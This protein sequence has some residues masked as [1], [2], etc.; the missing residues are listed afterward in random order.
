MEL[1]PAIKPVLVVSLNT[2][3]QKTLHFGHLEYGDV[4][5]A[6]LAKEC[7]G[8]KGVNVVRV[9]RM[10]GHHCMFAGF[11]GGETGALL[12]NEIVS[13]GAIDLSV[14]VQTKTRRCTTVISDDDGKVTELI[15]PSGDVSFS[16]AEELL[17]RIE[18]AVPNCSAVLFVGSVPPGTPDDFCEKVA[19]AANNCNVPF[20][21][22]AVA[23]LDAL[24]HGCFLLKVNAAELRKIAGVENLEEGAS[25]V[26]RKFPKLNAIGVTDGANPAHLFKGGHHWI[27]KVPRLDKIVS[28]IGG[29]DCTDAILTLRIAQGAENLPRAFAEALASATAS[30]LTDTP[31]AFDPELAEKLTSAIS[32]EPI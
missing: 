20:V 14:K 32:I 5:R 3:W 4:N 2:A 30:C 8:G 21:L 27:F 23:G 25:S 15:E 28:P 9:L 18:K 7:G 19:E 6:R 31:S 11:H 17:N 10:L 22:D 1:A 13:S 24:N 26:F 12:K 16:E 29:G